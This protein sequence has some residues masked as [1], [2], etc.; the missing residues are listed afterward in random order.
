MIGH[1][2][3]FVFGETVEYVITPDGWH[4]ISPWQKLGDTMK[5]VE[6]RITNA[7]ITASEFQE[8]LLALQITMRVIPIDS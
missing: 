4:A 6:A 5:T 7:T 3:K 1:E 8:A 2:F